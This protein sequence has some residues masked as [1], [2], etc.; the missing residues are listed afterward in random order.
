MRAS[1]A[2][3]AFVILLPLVACSTEDGGRILQPTPSGTIELRL[4]GSSGA[5]IQSSKKNPVKIHHNNFSLWVNEANYT[6][7]FTATIVSWTAP[8]GEPCWVP[9]AQPNNTILT[10]TPQYGSG[11]CHGDVEG[12]RVSDGVGHQTVQYFKNLSNGE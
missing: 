5:V 11:N 4:V 2:A 12:I 7:Y 3:V 8:T 9:P 6:D 10:F 1:L